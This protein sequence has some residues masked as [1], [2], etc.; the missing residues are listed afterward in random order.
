MKDIRIYELEH[1]ET[2]QNGSHYNIIT[3]NNINLIHLTQ[4]TR[5]I[6]SFDMV[7]FATSG[8]VSSSDLVYVKR[9]YT[10]SRFRCFFQKC[11]RSIV[12]MLW[13]MGFTNGYTV[14][15]KIGYPMKKTPHAT[16]Q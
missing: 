12:I 11:D 16:I 2:N 8:A 15:D 10:S 13:L 14:K 6:L 4:D 1:P 7:Q 3:N 9:Y 5:I